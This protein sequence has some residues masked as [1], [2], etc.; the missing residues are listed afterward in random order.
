MNKNYLFLI[1]ICMSIVVFSPSVSAWGNQVHYNISMEAL[2]QMLVEQP[3]NL[4]AGIIRDNMD[5]CLNGIEYADV[6]IR[7]YYTDYK[8]YKYLHD[9]TVVAELLR[10]AKDDNDRAFAYC[11]KFHLAEDAVSHNYVV[12]KAI[13][14][15]KLNDYLI[16]PVIEL[17]IEGNYLN[18]AAF[19]LMENH[20]KY[21]KLMQDATGTDWSADAA[22]LNTIFGGNKFYEEGFSHEGTTLISKV[23]TVLYKFV[24]LVSSGKTSVPYYKLSIEEAK[25]VMEGQTSNLDPSGEKAIKAA[26]EESNVWLYIISFIVFIMLLFILRWFKIIWL[27]NKGG[28]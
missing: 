1:L 26:E 11:Y 27:F 18:N 28:R 10:I 14:D 3:D 2:N 21:D 22:W 20:E 5:G 24:A 15:T 12:P 23:E 16:H 25:R 8:T 9:Y 7:Y 13:R 19:R 4:I 6:G 17:K